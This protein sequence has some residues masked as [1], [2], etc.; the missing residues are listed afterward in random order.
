MNKTKH[1]K[2]EICTGKW[3]CGMFGGH[4]ELK[5]I[6]QWI[7]SSLAGRNMN[8]CTFNDDKLKKL[9]KSY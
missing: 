6:I 9:S 4:V 3:G 5:F 7:S 8:F 2:V 1:N